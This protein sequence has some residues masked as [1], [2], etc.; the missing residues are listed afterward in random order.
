[1]F[2]TEFKRPT[3]LPAKLQAFVCPGTKPLEAGVLTGDGSKDVIVGKL[4]V[5]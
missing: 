2:A 5:K 3:M 1:V 4:S